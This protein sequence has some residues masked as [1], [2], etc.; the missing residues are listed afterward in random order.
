MGC[1]QGL[2]DEVTEDAVCICIGP[3][4]Q[5]PGVAL[6]IE[7]AFGGEAVQVLL[8]RLREAGCKSGL[9]PVLGDAPFGAKAEDEGFAGGAVLV[10]GFGIGGDGVVLEEGGLPGGEAGEVG[11]A[12]EA[13]EGG[14]AGA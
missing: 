4:G 3:G 5:P 12:G 8:E 6:E 10:E 1:V 14:S 11:G 2:L 7:A 13:V 9:E